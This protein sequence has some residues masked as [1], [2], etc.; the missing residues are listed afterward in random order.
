[1]LCASHLGEQPR[2]GRDISK[3]HGEETL[4]GSEAKRLPRAGRKIKEDRAYE[5]MSVSRE[6]RRQLLAIGHVRRRD[7]LGCGHEAV[8][9]DWYANVGYNAHGLTS[10]V[11]EETNVPKDIVMSWKVK[12]ARR[13]ASA[14][15]KFGLLHTKIRSTHVPY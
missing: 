1:M 9:I 5:R 4:G 11:G 12:C 14:D 3:R 6:I 13:L 2:C 15:L 10:V 8:T 7:A